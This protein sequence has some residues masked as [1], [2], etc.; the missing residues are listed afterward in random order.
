MSDAVRTQDDD[1]R[2]LVDFLD[3]EVGKDRWAMMLTADHGTNQDPAETGAFRISIDL[4]ESS[5]IEAFDDDDGVPVVLRT[6]PTQLW[7]DEGE[8]EDNGHT[9]AEVAEMIDG[10]TQADT[11]KPTLAP[12]PEPGERVFSAA[13]PSSILF[14]LPCLSGSPAGSA[15]D[16]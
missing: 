7:L 3:R 2:D 11:V 10:L 14:E 4:L 9:V 5:V 16:D 6:R 8:L 15:P 1:L 12:A 13:F